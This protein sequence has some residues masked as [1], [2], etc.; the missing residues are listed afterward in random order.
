M[1]ERCEGKDAR[2]SR[3]KPRPEGRVCERGWWPT[4]SR[5]E[6]KPRVR[7]PHGTGRPQAIERGRRSGAPWSKER[8]EAAE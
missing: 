3:A 7:R 6:H 2:A 4:P 1:S 5:N 8:A